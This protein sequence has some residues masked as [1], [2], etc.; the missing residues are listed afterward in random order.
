MLE[1][2]KKLEGGKIH[3]PPRALDYPDWDRLALRY[4]QYKAVV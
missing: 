2:L 3:L 4:E 1:A